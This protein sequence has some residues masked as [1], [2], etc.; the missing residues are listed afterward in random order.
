MARRMR[1][2]TGPLRAYQPV[3]W[4]VA[5][6]R[7]YQKLVSPFLGARCRF[8]PSCSTYAITSLERFG[9]FRG[10]RL[11]LGRL[12]RCHPWH[13]GGSDPVPGAP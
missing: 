12:A 1:Q 2:L 8:D 10:G 7:V 4:L 11:A 3:W 5:L 6:I 13:E 9:A